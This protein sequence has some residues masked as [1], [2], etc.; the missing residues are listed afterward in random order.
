MPATDVTVGVKGGP[1]IND[2]TMADARRVGLTDVA[3]VIENGS[4]APGT[5]LTECS[6]DF[7]RLFASANPIIAKGQGNYESL[8]SED[9]GRIPF[10]LKVKCPVIACDTGLRI[11]DLMAMN[12]A[13]PTAAVS[14][15]RS[16][17]AGI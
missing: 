2:A 9:R 12:S 10:L 1:V 11:G 14:E 5:L 6:G 7:L 13:P 8:A 17:N 4:D 3:S 15:G 16:E